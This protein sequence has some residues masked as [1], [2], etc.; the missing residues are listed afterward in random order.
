[1]D[2]LNSKKFIVAVLLILCSFALVVIGKLD[3]TGWMAFVGSVGAGYFGVN[4]GSQYI[5]KSDTKTVSNP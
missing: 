3:P 2:N 4:L 5:G 1:M